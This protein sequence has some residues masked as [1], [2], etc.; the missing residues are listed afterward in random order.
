[1]K[2]LTPFQRALLDST[3][4]QF[5]DVPDEEHIDITPT[6]NFSRKVEHIGHRLHMGVT[7]RRGLIAAILIVALVGSAFAAYYV[8]GLGE[9]DVSLFSYVTD[10]GSENVEIRVQF[11]D[12]FALSD[13]PETIETYYLPTLDVS[14]DTVEPGSVFLEDGTQA[15][16]PF[17]E[18]VQRTY[19]DDMEAYSEIYN[20]RIEAPTSFNASWSAGDNQIL[21]TQQTARS[22]ATD[23]ALAKLVYPKSWNPEVEIETITVDGFEVLSVVSTANWGEDLGL[24][25]TW[26]FWTD[27]SYLY[28]LHVSNADTAYM[29]ELLRSVQ[30]A[31]NINEYLY[32]NPED[33]LIRDEG[34]AGYPED[35]E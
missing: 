10:D 18:E 34:V 2:P 33:Y 17:L 28:Y 22:V 26:W 14:I 11:N 16:Y 27:G 13:A 3:A 31:E 1:M 19:L 4:R 5:D 35:G 15:F 24:S 6:R 29:A 23:K 30:P 12:E 21:F 20:H 7:L 8:A 9:T 32:P 25:Y